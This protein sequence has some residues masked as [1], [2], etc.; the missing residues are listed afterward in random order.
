MKAYFFLKFK[1]VHI[2][3]KRNRALVLAPTLIM[4]ITVHTY[5]KLRCKKLVK[6]HIVKMCSKNTRTITQLSF[7][8]RVSKN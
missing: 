8:G 7:G 3:E 1:S 2:L 6:I 4:H 5:N